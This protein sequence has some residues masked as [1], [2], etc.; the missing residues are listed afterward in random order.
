M[1]RVGKQL[2][3]LPAGVTATLADGVLTVKGPKGEIT[4]AFK[5]TIVI[6]LADNQITLAPA[7]KSERGISGAKALW[8]TY[9]AH[10]KNMIKGVSEGFTKELILEGIG[11]KS[12]V[13]GDSLN[14]ELGFSHSIKMPIPK[15]VTVT[16]EKGNITMKGHNLEILGQFAASVRALK[17][18][19]PYKGKGLRY[20]GERVL[21]KQGKKTTA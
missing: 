16:V 8:G 5:E 12:A 3:T 9:A 21:R 6:T 4:R 11:F 1:S 19:E 18:T 10:I 13:A 17:P 14:L 15:G 20:V 2:I 7:A